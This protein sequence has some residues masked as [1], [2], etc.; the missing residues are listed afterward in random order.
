[1]LR[2]PGDL[3]AD[4]ERVELPVEGRACARDVVLALVALLVDQALD[5]LVLARVQGGEREVLQLPL[6][7]VDAEPMRDRR[8]DLQGL[9]G[10]VDLLLL[11]QR[12]DRAHV[13]QAVGEL[14]ED[15]PDVRGHRD[16]HLAVVLRLRLVA[17]GERDAL[18]LRD[19]VDERRDLVTELLAHLGELGGR[20][21]DGVV[22]ERRAERLRVQ[23]QAGADLRDADRV[24]DELLARLA[25]LVGV[26]ATREEERL[27]DAV[28]VDRHRRL[29]GVLLD[30]R[31]EVGEQPALGRRQLG[32]VDR[33]GEAARAGRADGRARL[34][35]RSGR[36]GVGGQAA[37]ELARL[38][39][40]RP[41][42]RRAASARNAGERSSSVRSA[43]GRRQV[44]DARSTSTR[45]S[46]TRTRN[47]RP[48][49]ARG[50]RG[51]GVQQHVVERR[52]RRGAQGREQRHERRT[53]DG[54]VL[55]NILGEA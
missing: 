31:E 41:S 21:L 51:A 4:A 42:W 18:E 29:L 1:M 12:A 44:P 6:D 28:A 53:R 54:V 25:P 46:S 24:D 7:R 5:L 26:M 47:R 9:L 14:D 8:V 39:H 30:D 13:V 43:G 48:A 34:D 52:S 49:Y 38:R 35:A 55:E 32:V 17:R 27:D 23:A 36:R 16:H 45:P 10:L 2:A 19:A 11:G 15:D 22:Q 20:V 3:R 33:R 37:C 50:P 40:A